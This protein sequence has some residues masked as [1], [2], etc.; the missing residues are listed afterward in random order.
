MALRGPLAKFAY[1]S[2]R[3]AIDLRRSRQLY[4]D[5]VE[6]RVANE[7]ASDDGLDWALPFSEEVVEPRV[8]PPRIV[9][10]GDGLVPNHARYGVDVAM[11]ADLR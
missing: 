10:D 4:I 9:I 6:V 3:L 5:D 8:V 2:N 1:S 11:L 7:P